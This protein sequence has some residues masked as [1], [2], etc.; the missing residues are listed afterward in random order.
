MAKTPRRRPAVKRSPQ[1]RHEPAEPD[2][3]STVRSAL[4]DPGSLEL[5]G[6]VSSLMA[7]CD[8]GDEHPLAAQ[9]EK[10]A[11]EELAAMFMDVQAPET[12]AVL[13]VMATLTGDEV[14]RTR[15]RRELAARPTPAQDW[16][17]RLPHRTVH[18]A[19]RMGHVLDDG[20]NIMLGV[21][22]DGGDELTILVYIDHNL[23]T[24]VKDAF[25]IP[26]SLAAVIDQQRRVADDPDVVWE[27]LSLADARA[28]LEPAIELAAMTYPPYESETWPACKPVVQW[29][30][31]DLPD[32]GVGH[33]RPQW[34][35]QRLEDL[36]DRFFASRWGVAIDNADH[37]DLLDS[38]LWFATDYGP[39]DPLRWSVVR[40][41]ILF[42]DWLARKVLAP[43]EFL[44]AAPDLLRAFIGFAHAEARLRESLT[45]D[46]LAAIDDCAPYFLA[47]LGADR[48][49]HP[50]PGLID[51]YDLADM[52]LDYFARIVGGR[53]QLSDLDVHPLPDEPF[54]GSGIPEDITGRVSEV[55]ALTDRC[56]DQLLDTE[57]RTVARRLLA[58]IAA[59]DPAVF[60]R[61]GRAETAAAA[62]IWI[63]GKANGLFD[64]GPGGRH[65]RATDIAEHFGIGKNSAYQR[66]KPLLRAGGF[67]DD[68]YAVQL[69][70]PEFLISGYRTEIVA[71]RDRVLAGLDT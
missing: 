59:G 14:L 46:A 37:R 24:L 39:G 18:R 70:S 30:V 32:G 7:V 41:E 35:P 12:T 43:A 5:L 38:L 52:L 21:R 3:F 55:L 49:A 60:R 13:T 1:R 61:K 50:V 22:L 8:Q 19:V 34:D 4:A 6:F 53:Q 20:D 17:T 2:L 27:D 45:D 16:L 28:W 11:L 15:I 10:P 25:V 56:C 63:A 69:G 54:E 67:S 9:D 68:T 44:A 48:A 26:E 71:E 64:N 31:R 62:I 58:R 51:S 42:R 66:A 33:Q 57:Y 36:K 29:I 47:G 23:G 40:V 65:L